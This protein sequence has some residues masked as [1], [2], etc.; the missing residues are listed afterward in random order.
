M[1][2]GQ[3][4][5]SVPKGTTATIVPTVRAG[6]IV[7]HRPG[8]DQQV[9]SGIDAENAQPINVGSGDTTVTLNVNMVAGEIVVTEES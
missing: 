4:N 9:H 7:V 2:F 6:Q 5:V 1:G 3:L 8:E